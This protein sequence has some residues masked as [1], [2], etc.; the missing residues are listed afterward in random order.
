MKTLN[1]V[2]AFELTIGALAIAMLLP[3]GSIIPSTDAS[4]AQRV[5][6]WRYHWHS[7]VPVGNGATT[8][9]KSALRGGPCGF[10]WHMARDR[11][12]Y[13]D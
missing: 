6:Y 11:Q 5:P 2:Q 1:A 7:R 3:I 8:A 10:G 4:A 12:C 9:I 13:M